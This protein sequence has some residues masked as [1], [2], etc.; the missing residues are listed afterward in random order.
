MYSCS[1]SSDKTSNIPIQLAAEQLYNQQAEINRSYFLGH[2]NSVSQCINNADITPA[3]RALNK[4]PSRVL[5][6]HGTMT[7]NIKMISDYNTGSP[8]SQHTAVI[9]PAVSRQPQRAA[10]RLNLSE[11]FKELD[12]K[13]NEDPFKA[14][15]LNP[16]DISKGRDLF[17]AIACKDLPISLRKLPLDC[18]AQQI[19]NMLGII[20]KDIL[21]ED[22]ARLIQIYTG[23][24]KDACDY[25]VEKEI[26]KNMSFLLHKYGKMALY[27]QV[28]IYT[29]CCRKVWHYYNLDH[30]IHPDDN[31]IFTPSAEL[32]Y[33]VIHNLVNE[34]TKPKQDWV[35]IFC[36]GLHLQDGCAALGATIKI[37]PAVSLSTELLTETFDDMLLA[38]SLDSRY[39][40]PFNLS[41][42]ESIDEHSPQTAW[43]RFINMFC[44]TV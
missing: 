2:T 35:G 25:N 9:S 4:A 12:N 14:F 44:C 5:D 8:A 23:F 13:N 19:R 32:C 20:C 37:D 40:Y 41:E 15:I 42:T 3:N 28:E 34:L 27:R 18:K 21:P 6:A 26:A 30:T 1:T 22:R 7:D 10:Y 24:K 36:D 11:I 38:V 29:E 31:D 33:M 43:G 17:E 16:Q 39:P